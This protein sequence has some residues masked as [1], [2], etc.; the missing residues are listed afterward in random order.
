MKTLTIN[1]LARSERLDRPTISAVRGGWRVNSPGFSFGNL[2]YGGSDDASI[3]AVQNLGQ[4][5][6]VLTATANGAAFVGGVHVDNDVTQ[7]GE[8]SIVRR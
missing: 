2:N 3:S 5:Q 4:Q 8:N 6:N 1:D 7:R